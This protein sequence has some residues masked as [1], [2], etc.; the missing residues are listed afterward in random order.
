MEGA[1]GVKICGKDLEKAIAGLPLLVPR[2][3]D[4]IPILMVIL[5][6]FHYISNLLKEIIG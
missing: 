3:A 2:R 6:Y 1:Q 4:E 5:N